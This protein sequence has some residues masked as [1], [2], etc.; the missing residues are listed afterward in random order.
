V[1]WYLKVLR[2][3]YDFDGRAGRREYWTYTLI[4]MAIFTV[5]FV[6][7]SI[8]YIGPMISAVN[9]DPTAA[10]PQV[11]S[12]LLGILTG[13]VFGIYWL[14][15]IMPTLGVN[16]RR[17]HDTGRSGWLQLIGAIPFVGVIILLV[18]QLAEGD[19][20]PN[21]YGPPPSTT[22]TGGYPQGMPGGAG[23][24]MAGGFGQLPPGYPQQP[25]YPQA[26]GY[27]Q[28][29]GY[30]QAPGF[31]QSPDY[32]QAAASY[33]QAPGY[34]QAPDGYAQTPGYPQAPGYPQQQAYPQAPGYPQQPGGYPQAPGYPQQQAYPQAP[35]YPQQPGGYPQAPGYPQQQAYPQAP[36]YPQQPGYRQPS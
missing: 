17:L 10:P 31:A 6:L 18:L 35:G 34:P 28:Q 22:A 23:Y 2:Q 27:P 5:G 16:A 13:W 26:P 3:Y 7:Y 36:G 8:F 32:Q 14:A 19:P 29:P 9:T 15:T 21:V 4:N 11:P 25:G 33:A 12:T 20:G 24:P 30:P 1:D